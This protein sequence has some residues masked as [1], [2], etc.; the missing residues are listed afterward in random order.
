M[1]ELK[2]G[3]EMYEEE[4]HYMFI[5]V[6]FNRMSKEKE[7]SFLDISK[8]YTF[9]DELEFEF[10][11]AEMTP[12]I[13]PA[14]KNKEYKTIHPSE[15]ENIFLDIILRT[16]SFVDNQYP[17]D[18]YCGKLK[19]D[20]QLYDMN[21]VMESTNYN[22]LSSTDTLKVNESRYVHLY[23]EIPVLKSHEKMDIEIEVLSKE[24]YKYSFQKENEVISSDEKSV[25][26]VLSLVSSQMTMN[27]IE[28]KNK[29]EPSNK[30][31]FY[32]YIPTDSKDEIFIVLQIDIKNTSQRKMNPSE[33][34]YA[35]YRYDEHVI[36]PK[37]I[38]ESE[39]H[40]TL[41]KNGT[42]EPSQ[43]RTLYLAMPIDKKDQNKKGMIQ[44]FVEGKTYTFDF[45]N[46]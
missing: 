44:L 14:N 7:V 30:G 39:N 29:I 25:G 32:S 4:S 33:Y 1:I 34:I 40:Q 10:I 28:F 8:L 24:I 38:L 43:T 18:I 41:L 11:K 22:Q 35:E 31:F 16:V 9:Q 19:L 45:F 3:R 15:K 27:S 21:I 23:S 36:H 20:H 37:I 26:D 6:L 12:E 13:S 17:Y 42:I 46:D 2:K 5:D